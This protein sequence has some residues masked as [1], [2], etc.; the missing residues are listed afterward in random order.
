M[1]YWRLLSSQPARYRV[2]R[3][4]GTVPVSRSIARSSGAFSASRGNIST[5]PAFPVATATAPKLLLGFVAGL[6]VGLGLAIAEGM[7]A[8]GLG[9]MLIIQLFIVRI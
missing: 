6:G 3:A 7:M 4:P 8:G 5:A 1:E 2:P 9:V